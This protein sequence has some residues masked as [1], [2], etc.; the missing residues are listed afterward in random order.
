MSEKSAAPTQLV[1]QYY[2][3]IAQTSELKP[4]HHI[5][6]DR[7]EVP[8]CWFGFICETAEAGYFTNSLLQTAMLRSSGNDRRRTSWNQ[9]LLELLVGWTPGLQL[10]AGFQPRKYPCQIGS[11]K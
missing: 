3:G 8:E 5:E 10:V 2:K 11:D 1:H 7:Q 9:Q 6:M 4:N